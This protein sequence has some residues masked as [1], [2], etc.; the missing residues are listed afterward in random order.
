MSIVTW[1]I[2]GSLLSWVKRESGLFSISI[3]Y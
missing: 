3:I 2:F 1:V